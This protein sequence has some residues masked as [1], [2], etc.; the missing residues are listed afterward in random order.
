MKQVVPASNTLIATLYSVYQQQ[1]VRYTCQS[2]CTNVREKI[3]TLTNSGAQRC[4]RRQRALRQRLHALV[5]PVPPLA[6]RAPVR[7]APPE[8]RA[9]TQ[10]DAARGAGPCRPRRVYGRALVRRAAAAA[11][12]RADR[13]AR[14]AGRRPCRVCSSRRAR[15]A[16]GRRGMRRC[17]RR[18]PGAA[19]CGRRP[20]A[21]NTATVSRTSAFL[22]FCQP[23]SAP[24]GF[25][26]SPL[27][28]S[29][30][31]RQWKT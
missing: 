27:P 24:L 4:R 2:L 8:V 25:L 11:A 16:L 18:Q 19:C 5:P 20:C 30:R 28:I 12:L 13:P 26:L 7:H 31:N 15:G 10:A 22:S 9:L 3:G 1:P 21:C 23:S 17:C 29:Y 14:I 6:A